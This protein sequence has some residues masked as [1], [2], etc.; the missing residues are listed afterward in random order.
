MSGERYGQCSTT[1]PGLCA[2]IV[3]EEHTEPVPK[4]RDR[5]V[6]DQVLGCDIAQSE[7]LIFATLVLA[8][9]RRPRSG[10][11]HD[12]EHE[13]EHRERSARTIGGRDRPSLRWADE[14][15]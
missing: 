14:R 3:V 5:L 4:Q 12:E 9:E 10:G 6:P 15:R 1:D 7:A 13:D 8:S 2:R 11:S